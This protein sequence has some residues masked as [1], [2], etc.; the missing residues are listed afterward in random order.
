MASTVKDELDKANPNNLPDLMRSAVAGAGFATCIPRTELL[1]VAANVAVPAVPARQV[2]RCMASAA[3]TPGECT[4]VLAETVPI[5]TQC[6]CDPL[7][8]IEFAAAD[9]VTECQVTYMPVEG[10]LIT[11][12][13]PVTA[14]GVGTFNAGKVCEQIVTAV[15]NAPAITPGAKVVVARGTAVPA[16]G[17]CAVTFGGLTI[18]FVPGEATAI[19]TADVV[20]Y[21]LPGVGTATGGFGSRLDA[22]YNV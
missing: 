22:A 18:Q 14:G 3:G 2:V 13:I 15:L 19:C 12:T 7:G 11:E 20:Y 4:P 17:Q 9:V 6:A 1:A 10:E 16:G 8:Q 21:A 5:A